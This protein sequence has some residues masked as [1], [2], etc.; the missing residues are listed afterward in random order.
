[1]RVNLHR[2]LIWDTNTLFCLLTVQFA[3]AVH[4]RYVIVKQV[5]LDIRLC[6]E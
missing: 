6:G 1:M 4:S 5:V 2:Q 3:E